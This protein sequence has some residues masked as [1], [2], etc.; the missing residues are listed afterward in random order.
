[1]SRYEIAELE[2]ELRQIIDPTLAAKDDDTTDV[3]PDDPNAHLKNNPEFIKYLT[4]MRKFLPVRNGIF[5]RYFDRY[6]W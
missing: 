1:M 2:K 6:K 3:D 4:Q 5:K